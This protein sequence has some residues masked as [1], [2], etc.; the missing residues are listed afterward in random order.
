MPSRVRIEVNES[1]TRGPPGPQV[2]CGAGDD[3]PSNPIARGWPA[4]VVGTGSLSVR[5]KTQRRPISPVVLTTQMTAN[6]YSMTPADNP[7][8]RSLDA[9]SGCADIAGRAQ[10]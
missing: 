10:S 3:R 6:E 2:A 5:P 9:R 4:H 8:T 1:P 7:R